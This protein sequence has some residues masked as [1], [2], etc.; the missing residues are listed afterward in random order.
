MY[1]T[2]RAWA[3]AMELKQESANSMETRQRHHLVKRLKR[4][5][6]HASFLYDLCEQQT[7][8]SK[9]VFDVKVR[10]VIIYIYI[11]TNIWGIRPMLHL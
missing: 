1:E 8:D 4:A 6:Q 5:A 9:T 3:Y 2:E 7:V 10:V 11:K